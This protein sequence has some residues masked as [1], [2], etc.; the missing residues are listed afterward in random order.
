MQ[1]L[2]DVLDV[3]LGRSSPRDALRGI[4]PGDLDEDHIRDEAHCDQ[5][6]DRAEEPP[7]EEREH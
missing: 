2:A 6:Q 4:A 1:L 7:D 3:L 5:H